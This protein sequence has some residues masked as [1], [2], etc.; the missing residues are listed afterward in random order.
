M[1]SRYVSPS[2]SDSANG[3]LERPWKS[4]RKAFSSLYPGETLFAR[5]GVYAE[6]IKN[7]FLRRGAASDRIAV[8]AYP[9][10][11]PV[12]K[13]LLWLSKPSYWTFDGLN[14]QWDDAT[15]QKNEHMV[16]LTGGDGWE[17]VNAEVWGARSYA[18][19]LVAQGSLA[20]PNNWRI[21]GCRVRDTYPSN[22]TN[23]D[24]LIY[25][26]AGMEG[27][28]G[29]IERNLLWNATNGEAVKLGGPNA[30]E[31]GTAGVTVRYNTCYNTAQHMLVAWK[32]GGNRIE[33]N[34]LVKTKG[35]YK[36]LR[37]YQLSGAG[38]V[39]AENYVSLCGGVIANDPGYTGLQD[40]GGNVVGADPQF[41][42]DLRPALLAAQA[43]G[44]WAE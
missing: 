20:S 24:Q 10:E 3:T 42:G 26:N 38:N 43:Y 32:S 31:G 12:L 4:L 18:A 13:G 25:V 30:L 11:R 41:D 6:R 23:Q 17:F 1:E 8:K 2:G 33:R 35:S 16:K 39:A 44:R 29:I 37:G 22:D 5:G 19:I 40:G 14:V 27:T 7:P 21:S 36:S 9:G 15:G 28:G 34:L